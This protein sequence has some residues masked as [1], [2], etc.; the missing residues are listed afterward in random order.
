MTAIAIPSQS[1]KVEQNT[2]ADGIQVNI[3][4]QSLE[5]N[6][7]MA[8]NRLSTILVKLTMT[9]MATI[10]TDHMAGQQPAHQVGKRY[11]PGSEKKMGVVG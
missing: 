9:F 11:V 8:H 7:L 10:K 1:G 2:G 5:I 3:T 4:D 6:L